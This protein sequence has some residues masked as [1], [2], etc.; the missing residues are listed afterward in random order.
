MSADALR[1]ITSLVLTAAGFALAV[2]L[3]MHML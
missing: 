3:L 1:I 2:S